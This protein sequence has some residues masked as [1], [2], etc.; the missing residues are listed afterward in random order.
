MKLECA[1]LSTVQ[2]L[3]ERRINLLLSTS[4]KLRLN[5]K[6]ANGTRRRASKAPEKTSTFRKVLSNSLI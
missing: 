1:T 4:L 2:V 6:S 3:Y 5:G